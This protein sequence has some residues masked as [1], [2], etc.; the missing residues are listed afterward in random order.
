MSAETRLHNQ[1]SNHISMLACRARGRWDE[2]VSLGTHIPD[3]GMIWCH[4]SARELPCFQKHSTE[5]KKKKKGSR[6]ESKKPSRNII[7]AQASLQFQHH[8]D[9][10]PIS[11]HSLHLHHPSTST[12]PSS[13]GDGISHQSAKSGDCPNPRER[14]KSPEVGTPGP[15]DFPRQ[16]IPGTP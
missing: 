2:L 6:M 9:T 10:F 8:S 14:K 15:G 4:N 1:E 7:R 3:R 13:V 5:D 12:A 16:N 11:L